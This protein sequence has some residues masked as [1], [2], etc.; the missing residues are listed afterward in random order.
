MEVIDPEHPE[1]PFEDDASAVRN[2]LIVMILAELGIRRGEL[3]GVQVRDIDS[4][5]RTLTIHR[6]PD[7]SHDP[8]LDPPRAKTLA[9]KLPMSG[10]LTELLYGYVMGERRRT[11][12]AGTHRYLLVVHKKGEHEGVPLS[13]SGLNKVFQRLREC[14]PL[15]AALHPHALRHWWNFAF[16]R[17][18]DNKPK[19][20]RLSPEE[21]E[22]IRE[23]AMGWKKG[24]GTG[25]R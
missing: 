1:N 6:R 4:S 14:D 19:K 5:A 3:L 24:S 9:R 11:R 16:S 23:H 18:M 22:Q 7:D 17:E 21:L 10:E 8:R 2:R 15:L 25:E 13:K 12:S 20:E